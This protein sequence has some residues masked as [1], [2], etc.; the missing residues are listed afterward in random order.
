MSATPQKIVAT[1]LF[2][3][4]AMVFAMVVLGG[5]TR[6]TQSG[7]SITEW[8]PVSGW[9]PPLNDAAWDKV[10]TLYRTSPE[11]KKLNLGMTLAE[12]KAIFWLEYVHRLWGRTIGVAF[13]VPLVLFIARGWVGRPLAWRLGG[14][15][16]LGG[17]QGGLG[18]YMVKS[19]LVDHPDVSQY[20][21]AAHLGLALLIFAAILWTAMELMRPPAAAEIPEPAARGL[22]RGTFWLLALVFLTQ[23][24]GAFV[25]GLDAGLIYNTFPLMD[26]RLLPEEAFRLT[27]FYL[28]FFET[29]ALVQFDHRLLATATVVATAWL[30][31]RAQGAPLTGRQRRAVNLLAVAALVQASLGIATLLLVVPV[32]LAALHQAGAVALLAAGLWLA[33]ALGRGD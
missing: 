30:W 28:N 5:V 9:L 31:W 33:H 29:I 12:Y 21:L 1:W 17:L 22:R 6:L 4:A 19:G 8:W 20:R 25:A 24:S 7:L 27:P 14:L 18:W 16:V 23:L 32:P 15:F 13:L 26:G 11:Y 2:V 3:M 10:F